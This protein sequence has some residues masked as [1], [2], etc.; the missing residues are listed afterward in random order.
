MNFSKLEKYMVWQSQVVGDI[1]VYIMVNAKL[2]MQSVRKRF[3]EL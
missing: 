1:A 3:N 2:T